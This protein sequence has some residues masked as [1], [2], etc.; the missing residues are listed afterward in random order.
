MVSRASS[1]LVRSLLVMLG[2]LVPIVPARAL[3]PN[4]VIFLADDLGWNDVG[5][6]GS[7][8][9]TP[10]I[11]ALARGG[12]ILDRFYTQPVC[13]PTRVA[14]LTGVAP[15]RVCPGV[16]PEPLDCSIAGRRCA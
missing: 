13:T 3:P 4:I 2:V 14:L 10:H 16:R 11:D 9:E 1:S 6:Q 8:I 5:F 12:V 7:P 15:V